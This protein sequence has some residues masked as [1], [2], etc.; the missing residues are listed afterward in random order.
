MSVMMAT[1]QS[2]PQKACPW[3]GCVDPRPAWDVSS[4]IRRLVYIL[5]P[6]IPNRLH[7]EVPTQA[8]STMARLQ[9]LSPHLSAHHV[10][11]SALTAA[12]PILAAVRT[13]LWLDVSC[14]WDIDRPGF[15]SS[16][17]LLYSL[18][19]QLRQDSIL[20]D[21]LSLHFLA[22]V[23]DCHPLPRLVLLLLAISTGTV[24]DRWHRL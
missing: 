12:I 22:T 23:E 14:H 7:E 2:V 21:S 10:R 11:R 20:L 16:L 1:A 9:R 5:R 15:V 6:F 4:A 18:S 19:P 24:V 3:D 17:M 8:L 13:I